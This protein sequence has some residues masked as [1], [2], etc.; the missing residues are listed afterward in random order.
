L[1][2]DWISFI[3]LQ[4]PP[5]CNDD[6][7]DLRDLLEQAMELP[8]NSLEG[9]QALAEV[10]QWDSLAIL[11]FMAL[12]DSKLGITL[13]ADKLLECESVA[14]VEALLTATPRG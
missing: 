12:V 2:R 6:G 4:W 5:S 7:M 14:D 11:N 3:D 8:A 9:V 10:E 13:A 1:R